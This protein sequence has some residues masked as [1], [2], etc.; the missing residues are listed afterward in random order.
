MIG[1]VETTF[2]VSGNGK[3]KVAAELVIRGPRE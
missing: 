2:T 1:A 3:A